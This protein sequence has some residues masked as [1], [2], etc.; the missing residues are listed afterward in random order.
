MHIFDTAAAIA[1]AP[2]NTT[3]PLLAELLAERVRDWASHG[4]LGLTCLLVL[5]AGDTEKSIIE[6][7]AFSPLANT[8]LDERFGSP[9][10]A[11]QFDWLFDAGGFFELIQTVGDG[12]FAFHIFVPD[13]QGVDPEL[14]ALCRAYADGGR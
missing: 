12:G 3:D 11:P 9:G 2:Q 14:L 4:L 6:A 1:A 13:R 10:F 5:E 7:A 8:L